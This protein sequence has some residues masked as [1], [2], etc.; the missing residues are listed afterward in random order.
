MTTV[1]IPFGIVT[2]MGTALGNRSGSGA[3]RET[4][5]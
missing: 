4:S 3:T 2:L 1:E 5:T